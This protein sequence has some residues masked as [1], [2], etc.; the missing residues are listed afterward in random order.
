MFTKY[1]F[2]FDILTPHTQH[3]H[4]LPYPHPTSTKKKQQQQQTNI[5]QAH[6]NKTKQNKKPDAIKY[7]HQTNDSM[8]QFNCHE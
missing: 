8:P 6:K 4:L 2:N 1:C 3:T 7:L 5:K